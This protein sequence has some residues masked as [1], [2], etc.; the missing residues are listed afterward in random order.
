MLIDAR[1]VAADAVVRG[2]LCII[3]AGAAGISIAW[4]LRDR[5]VRVVLLES[6]SF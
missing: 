4:A 1:T 3:G 6:G 5:P 2:D